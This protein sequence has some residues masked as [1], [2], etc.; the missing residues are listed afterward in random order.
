MMVVRCAKAL[1]VVHRGALL[2][3]DQVPPRLAK[4]AQ[5]V[6]VVRRLFRRRLCRRLFGC[7]FAE[8]GW[9]AILRGYVQLTKPHAGCTRMVTNPGRVCARKYWI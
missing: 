8:R 4:L 9:R 7:R 2:A 6:V 5:V 3:A 1:G